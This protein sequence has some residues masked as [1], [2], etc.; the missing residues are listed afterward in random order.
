VFGHSPR[1]IVHAET[2]VSGAAREIHV[3]K[4]ER[5]EALIK[6]SDSFPHIASDHKKRSGGLIHF[7]L[8]GVV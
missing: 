5:M 2:G 8:I 3:F 7:L 1:C 4:P 6:T